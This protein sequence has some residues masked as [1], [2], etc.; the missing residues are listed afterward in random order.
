VVGRIIGGSEMKYEGE[1]AWIDGDPTTWNTRNGGCVEGASSSSP[2][3]AFPQRFNFHYSSGK[4]TP[5]YFKKLKRGDL[6]PMQPWAQWKVDSH[7]NG[8]YDTSSVCENDVV[9]RYWYSGHWCHPDIAHELQIDEVYARS[10]IPSDMGAEQVQ[11]AAAAIYNRG[12]DSLT[13]IAEL[14]LALRMFKNFVKRLIVNVSRA[15]YD[16][17][18]LE[19]RYGWRTLLYDMQD[20]EMVLANLDDGRVRF[21]KSVESSVSG[22]NAWQV[23]FAIAGGTLNLFFTEEWRC[24]I[25]G[26]VVADIKPPKFHFNPVVTGWEIVTLSFVIDWVVDVGQW[27]AAMSFLSLAKD[28]TQAAGYQLTIGRSLSSSMDWDEDRSGSH[29]VSGQSEACLTLRVPQRVSTIP[30]YRLNLD[31]KKVLDLIAILQQVIKRS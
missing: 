20:I 8:T 3:S 2:S 23:P 13:F 26:S 7:V 19:W 12:W 21:A 6:I 22:S 11:A 15:K 18:W 14:H 1:N 25:R 28:H 29:S 5:E 31:S 4:N 16:D 27:L 9:K 17:I 30:H 24:S 10:L